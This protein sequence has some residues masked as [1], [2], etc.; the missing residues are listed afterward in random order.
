[1]LISRFFQS[2]ATQWENVLTKP[3]EQQ[4]KFLNK[5]CHVNRRERM[6]IREAFFDNLSFDLVKNIFKLVKNVV[7][8]GEIDYSFRGLILD[9]LLWVTKIAHLYPENLDVEENIIFGEEYEVYTAS[10]YDL[11][12]II[13]FINSCSDINSLCDLG[14][15]SGRALLYIALEVEKK[16]EYVGLELVNDRVEFTNMI[17]KNFCLDNMFFKTSNFLKTPEDLKGFDAYYLYDPVGTD[18]V[19]LLISHFKKMIDDG[20]KFYIIFISGWDHLMLDAL[21]SLESLKQINSVSSRKQQDR[22]VNF[23]KVI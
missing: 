19:S 4:S 17:A 18:D 13:E 21:N 3:L 10:Y 9:R 16:L 2:P 6:I 23:Y 12:I 1:M 7:D 14:S 8:A 11:D 15:G 20:A 5:I 22:F